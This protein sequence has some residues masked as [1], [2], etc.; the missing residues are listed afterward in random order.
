MFG[1]W[2]R[3]PTMIRMQ[4]RVNMASIKHAPLEFTLSWER[5]VKR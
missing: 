3:V 1:E 5:Q 2:G 4:D